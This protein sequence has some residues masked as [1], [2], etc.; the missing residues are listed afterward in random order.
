MSNNYLHNGHEAAL[1]LKTRLN[2]HGKC[3]IIKHEL[4]MQRVICQ[5]YKSLLLSQIEQGNFVFPL[6]ETFD[7]TV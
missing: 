3:L 2:A 6:H 4:Y 7:N 5:K 1:P